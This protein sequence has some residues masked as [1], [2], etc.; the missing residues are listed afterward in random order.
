MHVFS[1]IEDTALTAEQTKAL[2]RYRTRWTAIRRS[3]EPADRGAAE[4]GVRLAYRAAGLSP[5]VRFLWCE[6]PVAL[7][8]RALSVVVLPRFVFDILP[9][10][11]NPCPASPGPTGRV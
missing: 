1:R 8:R 3:T 11:L 10:P 6:G 7:S 5:P 4:E 2:V 9:L